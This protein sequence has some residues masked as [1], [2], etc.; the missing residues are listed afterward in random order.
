MGDFSEAL[1]AGCQSACPGSNYL[2]DLFHFLHDNINWLNRRG[3]EQ[4]LERKEKEAGLRETL[5]ILW[6]SPTYE[7]FANNVQLFV[8]LSVMIC[9]IVTRSC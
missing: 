1:R 8:G 9:Y 4:T 3:G 7:E 5:H 2:G 6:W